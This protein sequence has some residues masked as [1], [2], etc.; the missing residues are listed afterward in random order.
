ME[1]VAVLMLIN[2]C[3]DMSSV[4]VD[5]EQDESSPILFFF[6]E[7]GFLTELQ[8]NLHYIFPGFSI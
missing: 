3:H 2:P 6:W 1:V 4:I 8:I 7:L 5:T